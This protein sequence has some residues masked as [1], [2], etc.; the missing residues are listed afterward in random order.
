MLDAAV[1]V[2]LPKGLY[3]LLR[4]GVVYMLRSSL[5]NPLTYRLAF[6]RYC[7]RQYCMVYGIQKRGLWGRVLRNVYAIVLQ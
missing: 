1:G 2:G 6:A 4:S 7:H 5:Y 3:K